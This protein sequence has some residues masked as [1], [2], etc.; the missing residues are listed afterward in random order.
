[1]LVFGVAVIQM[2]RSRASSARRRLQQSVRGFVEAAVARGERTFAILRREILPNIIS[3]IA[4]DVG[5]R[6][7]LSII[8]VASVNFLGLGLQ[9][10]AADWALMISENR[11]GLTLNPCA[12]LAPAADD[13]AA[14]D[15]R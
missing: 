4:A 15:R 1:M 7:T 6:F 3:P 12:V 14:H 13:R 2:P 8:L 9:P 11:A 10:P 5:L